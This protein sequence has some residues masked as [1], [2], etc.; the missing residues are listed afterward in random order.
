MRKKQILL[1]PL[2]TCLVLFACEY[3]YVSP[4]YD[5]EEIVESV[6]RIEMIN[7][8][9]PDARIIKIKPHLFIPYNFDFDKMEIIE[10][11]R[12]ERLDDFLKDF[13]EF[14]IWALS[15]GLDSPQ[16]LGIRVIR[17]NGDFDLFC[18]AEYSASFDS[19]GDVTRFFGTG[20]RDRFD[21]FVKK[22]FDTQL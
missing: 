17:K 19:N 1:L 20:L 2:L 22:Y 3:E 10:V 16:G 7:Y 15:E 13:F 8:N 21:S 4:D 18:K 6:A 9:N 12:E 11:L 14:G 5:Y